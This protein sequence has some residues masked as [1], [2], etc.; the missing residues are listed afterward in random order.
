M[1]RYPEP[2][3]IG[4]T[5]GV[6]ATSSGVE[7]ELHHL[8]RKAA[9]QFEKRGFSVL[10]GETVWTNE[11]L[12][13]TPKE[14]RLAEFKE[15]ME[16]DDVYAVIPPWGGH[17]LSE[18]LPLL[19][20][21]EMKP[22]WI[23]GYSD[24]ST[25][26]LPITLLTGIATVHGT[27]FVDLRSDAWDPVTS[28]FIEVLT[29]SRGE[30][31][32]QP[33]SEKHQSEWQHFAPSDP[34]VFKLDTETEWKTIGNKPVRFEGRL[35][36]GCIDTIRHLVGTPFGDVK[37]FQEEFIAGE[38]IVWALENSDMD[39]P[40][41]YRSILQLHNAGWFD[42]AAGIVFGRTAAGIAKGG[43]SD[44][45]ALER[46]GELTGLP[47]AYDADIGHVPPQMTFV[48]GAYAE[49]EVVEGKAIMKT[50]LI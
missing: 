46:L 26:L 27:N 15:M 14:M 33:S 17:F 7:S 10:L 18:I 45:D 16:D 20:F 12:T 31:I 6:T 4:Q 40:D 49:I 13:S 48:N 21:G 24:T 37:R 28:K 43:F 3:K 23:V 2:L 25:L 42:N 30:M 34:Y 35:L 50:K 19:N 11:K 1:I 39:A 29:A 38:K 8:L 44:V 5:I 9:H 47:I 36:A 32:V 41:F 22:K